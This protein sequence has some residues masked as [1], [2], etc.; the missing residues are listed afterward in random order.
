M[1]E[2][3]MVSNGW[4]SKEVTRN[5]FQQQWLDYSG[6]MWMLF[7]DGE[8]SKYL[9]MQYMIEDL[10]GK[11]WDRYSPILVRTKEKV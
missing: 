11:T 9:D 6:R 5:E 3:K 7:D 10:A 2:K 4:G 1:E 8:Y